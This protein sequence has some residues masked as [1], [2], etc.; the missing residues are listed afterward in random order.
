MS[1]GLIEG[2]SLGVATRVHSGMYYDTE[3]V[4]LGLTYTFDELALVRRY[5][6]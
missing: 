4:A 2:Q 5:C 6:L 3:A 1:I